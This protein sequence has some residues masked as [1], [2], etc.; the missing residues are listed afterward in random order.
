MEVLLDQ[1]PRR[2]WDSLVQNAA[3]QQ[4]WAYG[5]ACRTLGSRILRFEI[6]EAG[7]TIGLAQAVHRRLFGCLHA[8]VCTR[9]P[10]WNGALEPQVRI[11]ALSACRRA[12]PFSRLKGFFMTPDSGRQ[13][14]DILKSGGFARVMTPYTTAVIDLTKSEADLRAAMHQKWRNRL[15]AAERSGLRVGRADRHS[16]LYHW[17]LEAEHS[18]QRARRYS[19]IPVALVPAW[20][21]AGGDLRV[22]TASKDGEILAAMLFLLHG[23]RATYHLGWSSEDGKKLSAHNLLLWQAVL[24]LKAKGLRLLDLGGLNTEDIPGI[25]RFKL[26]TGA[27]PETLCGTWFG[28]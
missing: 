10:V 24:K 26:G 27:K 1:T 6:R 17:L 2:R 21:Q 11:D 12:L 22:L 8:V 5:E 3:F 4:D 9:G 13:E 14:S 25:A 28:R 20:Q 23:E 18:Q 16:R 15:V 7:Q 19:A